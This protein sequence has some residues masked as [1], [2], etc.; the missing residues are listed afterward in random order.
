MSVEE[1]QVTKVGH[2]D[3][4]GQ[5]NKQQKLDILMSVEEKQVTKVGHFDVN[6]RKTNNK[7]WTF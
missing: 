5:K 6:G 1:K 3:V 7:S 4:N 2:F